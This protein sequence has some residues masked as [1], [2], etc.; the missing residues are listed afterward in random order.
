MYHAHCEALFW[1][2]ANLSRIV[3]PALLPR[4]RVKF[5]LLTHISLVYNVTSLYDASSWTVKI[6]SHHFNYLFIAY[7]TMVSDVLQTKEKTIGAVCL[8]RSTTTEGLRAR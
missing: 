7:S 5:F 4:D 3:L 1:A 6:T 2:A 8:R